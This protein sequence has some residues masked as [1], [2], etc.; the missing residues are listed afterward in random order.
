M[1]GGVPPLYAKTPKLLDLLNEF[2]ER[3]GVSR[4]VV[5]EQIRNVINNMPLNDVLDVIKLIRKEEHF[6][7]LM[8]V[9]MRGALYYAIIKRKAEMMGL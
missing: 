8:G 5:R 4:L 3:H 7:I 1:R 2:E 6:N 9:G